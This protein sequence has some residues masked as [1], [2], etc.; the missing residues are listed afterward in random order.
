MTRRNQR[1]FTLLE[2]LVALSILAVALG[3]LIQSGG[4]SANTL[5]HLRD[6][7]LAH[8]VASNKANELQL[9]NA[10]PENRTQKG[11][12]EPAD[13]EWHW[14]MAVHPT[15]DRDLKRIEIEVRL[16]KESDSS[17]ARV[18]T[19]LTRPTEKITQ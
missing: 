16:N 10:W 15:A 4:Q 7:T 2:V 18:V 5:S 14:Q 6:K 8:W 11:E 1:G 3:A 12:S 9:A 13:L 17:L 19:L